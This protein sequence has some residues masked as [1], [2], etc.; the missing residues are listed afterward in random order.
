M[1]FILS[2]DFTY[3][4]SENWIE[5]ENSSGT[6]WLRVVELAASSRSAWR[7]S[8]PR[9]EGVG[10][11]KVEQDPDAASNTESGSI[12]NEINPRGL[13][14]PEVATRCGPSALEIMRLGHYESTVTTRTLFL[15]LSLAWEHSS[16]GL[17][18]SWLTLIQSTLHCWSVKSNNS[19]QL[20]CGGQI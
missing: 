14:L 7:P 4:I 6:E 13:I 19:Q 1:V 17:T 10:D 11:R 8:C 2:L 12:Q 3:E 16:S 9:T 15:A 20:S 18:S 5:H